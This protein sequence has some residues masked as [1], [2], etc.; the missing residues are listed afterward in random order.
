MTS[1]VAPA[2]AAR[3]EGATGT[4][5]SS[6]TSTWKVRSG[7]STAWKSRSG[8]KGTTVVAESVALVDGVPA[9]G[10]SVAELLVEG[11]S[12]EVLAGRAPGGVLTDDAFAEVVSGV[13]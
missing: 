5:R 12:T 13:G 2:R 8:P 7:R 11:A 3:D 6:H 4:Q 10:V 1:T 9:G